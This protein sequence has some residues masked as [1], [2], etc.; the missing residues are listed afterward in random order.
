[1]HAGGVLQGLACMSLLHTEGRQKVKN[2]MTPWKNK[3]LY[4]PR[5]FD[6]DQYSLLDNNR[7]QNYFLCNT[8]FH[9]GSWDMAIELPSLFDL[10]CSFFRK[11]M[12]KSE[13]IK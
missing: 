7:I 10:I 6:E 4:C 13:K 3:I 12:S 8:C 9:T 5:C 2:E 11:L 1:V